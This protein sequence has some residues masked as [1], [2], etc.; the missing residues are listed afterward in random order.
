MHSTT[1]LSFLIFQYID[2]IFYIL[3]YSS[4]QCRTVANKE[5]QLHKDEKRSQKECLGNIV[6]ESWR[7]SLQEGMSQ[8]LEDPSYHVDAN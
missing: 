3:F 5:E 7:P 1:S 6:K 2:M 4:L 8:K